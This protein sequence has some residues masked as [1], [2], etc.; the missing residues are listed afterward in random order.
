MSEH[1]GLIGQPWRRPMTGRDPGG[2][3]G[4]YDFV[5]L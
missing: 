4:E 2:A 1:N 3:L 5:P